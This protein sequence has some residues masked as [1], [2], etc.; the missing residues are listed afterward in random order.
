MD[1][2]E[3]RS[4][5]SEAIEASGASLAELSR[6]LGRNAAWLQQYLRR[7]TP[8]LLPEADRRRLASYLG[9]TDARLGGPEGPLFLPRLDIAASAG[10]GRLVDAETGIGG[11]PIA[12]ETL[13]RMGARPDDC[14]WLRVEG[15][16]M[17]P[18]LAEGDRILVDRGRRKPDSRHLWV[19]RRDGALQVK[20]LL[21]ERGELRV[22]SDNPDYG[23][24]R[25]P[26][27]E[28]E[29]VGRVLR[30]MRDL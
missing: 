26:L 8:R 5:L 10:P 13:R 2:D 17:A 28:V 6:K 12:P 15:D 22:L 30:L 27:A 1:G 23:E 11:E 19:I 21:P 18:L 29:V 24:E 4:A 9:V 7:G 25:V 3:Q 14:G 20:R 16:S